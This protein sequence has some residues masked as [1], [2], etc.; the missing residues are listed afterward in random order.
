MGNDDVVEFYLCPRCLTPGD[1]S[2]FCSVCGTE[3]LHCC[4]GESDD[5]CRRPLID[6]GMVRTRAPL[7]WL[8]HSVTRITKHKKQD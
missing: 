2:G 7:W 1:S 4:P 8:Q 5:P 6:S 3:R